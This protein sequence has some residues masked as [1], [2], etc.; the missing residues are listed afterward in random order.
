LYRLRG[1]F[2]AV[3]PITALFLE[4]SEVT[5]GSRTPDLSD[6]GESSQKK[7]N[8]NYSSAKKRDV[9]QKYDQETV[10]FEE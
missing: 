3:P 1:L 9:A 7:K 6:R 8:L 5:G 4:K 2:L 10:T